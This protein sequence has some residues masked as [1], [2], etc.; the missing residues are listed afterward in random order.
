MAAVLLAGRNKSK[1]YNFPSS[2]VEKQL[3]LGGG[4]PPLSH[5]HTH[6]DTLLLQPNSEPSVTA[7][8][9]KQKVSEYDSNIS[10]VMFALVFM[11]AAFSLSASHIHTDARMH[12]L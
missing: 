6:T 4:C 10:N 2:L 9:E 8:L 12:N 1:P 3:P 5:A 11:Q 7:L